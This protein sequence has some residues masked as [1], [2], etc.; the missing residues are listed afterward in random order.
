MRKQIT[1]S[2]LNVSV[3]NLIFFSPRK[4][5]MLILVCVF[6]PGLHW[7]EWTVGWLRMATAS[8]SFAGLKLG[9]GAGG[10]AFL[11]GYPCYPF[12]TAVL[13]PLWSCPY[14]LSQAELWT[15]A[16]GE[17][18][19]GEMPLGAGCHCSLPHWGQALETLSRC[20]QCT[21]DVT[22]PRHCLPPAQLF[23]VYLVWAPQKVG[24]LCWCF[25]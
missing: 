12:P 17:T 25:S 9:V 11:L 3:G 16:F 15:T 24:W 2:G 1:I 21:W 5:V 8:F 13:T 4:K 7:T 10:S 19:F 18:Q 22:A 23:S 20:A 14:E 6:T